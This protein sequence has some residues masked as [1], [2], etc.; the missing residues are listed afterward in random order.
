[1]F[2]MGNQWNT[3]DCE[4]SPWATD[5]TPTTANV[6]HGRPTEHQRLRIFPV[7]D[8]LNTNDC[9]CSPWAT[10]RTDKRARRSGSVSPRRTRRTV[11]RMDRGDAHQGFLQTKFPEE[12]SCPL[13]SSE[14]DPSSGTH[15]RSNERSPVT[16]GG[17]RKSFAHLALL[18]EHEA[19]AVAPAGDGVP[20]AEVQ[21]V[22]PHQIV[23][24]GGIERPR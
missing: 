19:V 5:R 10:I 6:P 20:R 11:H 14:V 22:A 7:G 21:Q 13:T 15:E 23:P 2:P 4:Y 8:Q 18:S 17:K 1:M 24:G 16:S 12:T 3:N 9:E